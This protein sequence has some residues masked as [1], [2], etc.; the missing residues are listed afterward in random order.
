MLEP[1][2]MRDLRT[3]RPHKRAQLLKRQHQ[4]NVVFLEKHF[5]ELARYVA[6]TGAGRFR[7]EADDSF[8]SVIDGTTGTLLHPQGELIRFSKQ[9]GG[10]RHGGWWEYQSLVTRRRGAHEHDRR[11]FAW[12]DDLTASVP[13]LGQGPPEGG[14][15]L[16]RQSNGRP[17]VPL[18]LF[19]GL[20]TGLHVACYLNAVEAQDIVLVEP[21]PERFA[22]S[23]LFLDY[24]ELH[25]RFGHLHLVVGECDPDQVLASIAREFPITTQVWVRMLRA[26]DSPL[27]QRFAESAGLHFR[28]DVYMPFDREL[29]ALGWQR[30]NI[31]AGRPHWQASPGLSENACIVVIG[32]GPSLGSALE[33]LQRHRDHLILIAVVS[34]VRPLRAAG[35]RPDFQCVLDCEHSASTLERLE[36][37]ADVPLIASS[38]ADPGMLGRFREVLLFAD[39]DAANV[40]RFSSAWKY[41][42]P[43]SGNLALV[44][45]LKCQPSR[46]LLVGMDLGFP[47]D[48]RSHAEGTLH[49]HRVG[50]EDFIAP[51]AE[52]NNPQ[53]VEQWVTTPYLTN[54]RYAA[55]TALAESGIDVVNLSDG[56]RIRGAR[57]ARLASIEIDRQSTGVRESDLERIRQAFSAHVEYRQY[58][59][60]PEACLDAMVRPLNALGQRPDMNN[61]VHVLDDY[62]R[63]LMEMAACRDPQDHRLTVFRDYIRQLLT[64]WYRCLIQAHG[65]SLETLYNLGRTGLRHQLNELTW[66]DGVADFMRPGGRDCAEAACATYYASDKD[67]KNCL[68]RVAWAQADGQNFETAINLMEKDR[69]AERMTANWLLRLAEL[70]QRAGRRDEALACVL[71]TYASDPSMKDGHARLARISA[72]RRAW[73][74]AVQLMVMDRDADRLSTSGL[75]EYALLSARTGSLADA[76]TLVQQAYDSAPGLRDVFARLGWV[77][78]EHGD[79]PTVRELMSRD[80]ALARMTGQWRLRYAAVF[81]CEDRKDAAMAQISQ[82]YASAPGLKDGGASVAWIALASDVPLSSDDLNRLLDCDAG[83][84]RSSLASEKVRAWFEGVHGDPEKARVLVSGYY[85]R[86]PSARDDMAGIG[87]LLIRRGN[88]SAGLRFMADDLALGR[89]SAPWKLNYCDAL[90]RAGDKETARHLLNELREWSR[91]YDEFPIGFQFRPDRV[92]AGDELDALAQ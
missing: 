28:R 71:T 57:P 42:A 68:A 1:K 64:G 47:R 11:L 79:L 90:V 60:S 52:T 5:P 30:A 18:T 22:L 13:G 87:W 86:N 55:E 88:A 21:D 82:A 76:Q 43:T 27:F 81:W 14:S 26:Y 7:L 39:M 10:I 51:V 41:T 38:K 53:S 3:A 56:V 83:Q 91:A 58:E 24:A 85:A 25:R 65:S 6:R 70:Y 9:L 62:W 54:A 45:A 80:D 78:L 2:I 67:A 17:F 77:Y 33:W 48:A 59:W 50:G 69:Q 15:E 34:A 19:L 74:N 72:E 29:R 8:I 63:R 73:R 92:L 89:M 66:P 36:L 37:D 23:C 49:D 4:R 35:I 20:N 75:V 44:A 61:L 46:I 32:A 84:G 40:V 12:L 31:E 16:P